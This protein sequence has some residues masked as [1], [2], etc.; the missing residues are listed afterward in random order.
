MSKLMSY[1][2]SILSPILRMAGQAALDHVQ[3]CIENRLWN[4]AIEE[5]TSEQ[6]RAP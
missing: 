6:I 5:K 2:L 1:Y 3:V 4:D